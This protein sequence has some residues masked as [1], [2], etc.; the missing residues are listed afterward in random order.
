MS[1][2]H[3]ITDDDYIRNRI[4]EVGIGDQV[5]LKGWLSSYK[6]NQGG[7]RG[8]SIT[9][10]DQGNGA[11]ETIYVKEFDIL[12]EYNNAWRKLMYFSLA[13]FLFSLVWYFKTPHKVR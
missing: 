5:R 7:E 1:N 11:C 10:E 3:L 6:N 2:N 8:T 13:L 9:R 4:E 12:D